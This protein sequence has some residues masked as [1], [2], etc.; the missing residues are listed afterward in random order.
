MVQ[1]SPQALVQVVKASKF[2]VYGNELTETSQKLGFGV[3]EIHSLNADH[4]ARFLPVMASPTEPLS[5]SRPMVWRPPSVGI[6][7]VTIL[8]SL[9]VS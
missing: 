2:W 7:V 3:K 1:A 5:S 8:I 9:V 4:D 6:S